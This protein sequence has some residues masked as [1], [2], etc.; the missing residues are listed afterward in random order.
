MPRE[1][2]TA[3]RQ[4]ALAVAEQMC[5]RDRLREDGG[6]AQHHHLLG[7]LRRLE[8]GAQGHL[9]L[10]YTSSSARARTPPPR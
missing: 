5:I 10:L 4:R 3:K 1:T 9:C 6:G 7:V 8:R 2:M